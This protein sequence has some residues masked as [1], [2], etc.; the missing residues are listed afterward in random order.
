MKTLGI[1]TSNYTTSAAVIGDAG[2]I[3]FA[4]RLLPVRPGEYG[5]R[6]NEALFHHTSALPE[7]IKQALENNTD[8]DAVGVS[9]RPE[10]RE[11]SYM[12]CFSAGVTAA[13]IISASL[14][15]P[16]YRFSHQTGHIAA[17]ALGANKPELLKRPFI[18]FHLSGGTTQ[19][20]LVTPD[21]N[22]IIKTELIAKSLD[23]KAGQ[24][25]D[26]TGK[27]LGLPFPSGIELEKSALG[28]SLIKKP[29]LCLKGCDCCLSGL[30]NQCAQLK[31]SGAENADIALF[32][33]EFIGE[34]LCEMTKRLMEKYGELPLLYAG[35]VMSNTIIR[36]K[37]ERRF[38]GIF[39]PPEFS[40]DN[41]T[42][43]ACL[44]GI[45]HGRKY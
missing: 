15:I 33:L 20:L 8:I 44:A 26:R 41:A 42:G 3:S 27:L 38:G 12:P 6:Q 1:D 34:T 21:E 45:K 14:G 24:A 28:G 39:A 30:E 36:E 35:G 23:L 9:S 4:A 11:D 18:A 40:R 31:E 22:E 29:V 7:I 37:V 43:V 5:V 19:A 2:V 10:S 16:V 13:E 25:V 32:C 17:A